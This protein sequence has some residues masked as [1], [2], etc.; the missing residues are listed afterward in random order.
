M[1]QNGLWEYDAIGR[2]QESA[3]KEKADIGG[4]VRLG[5][6][7]AALLPYD[8]PRVLLID[9]LDKSAIHLPND[10]LAVF[11][12]GDFEIQPLTRIA[13]TQPEGTVFTHNR[14]GCGPAGVQYRPFP[15]VVVCCTR[16]IDWFRLCRQQGSGE[17]GF[18][19]L[20]TAMKALSLR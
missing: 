10:L 18:R 6:L 1:S 17:L 14:A 16:C 4:L 11:E 7:G 19:E 13:A 15:I 3:A 5:P 20:R 8:R 12:D 2:V 9:E